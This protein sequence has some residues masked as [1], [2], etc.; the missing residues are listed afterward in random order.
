MTIVLTFYSGRFLN[1]QAPSA[2]FSPWVMGAAIVTKPLGSWG[3]TVKF[4]T[5]YPT[6]FHSF[7]SFPFKTQTL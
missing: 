6:I 5:V 4:T 7:T 3:H 2:T 1:I